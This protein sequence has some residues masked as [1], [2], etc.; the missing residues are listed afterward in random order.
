[1]CDPILVKPGSHMLPTY[2]GYN[3]RHGL[4]QRCGICKHPGIDR[5][6]AY[7]VELSSTSA[8]RPAI[9]GDETI[10]CEHHLRRSVALCGD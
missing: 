10:L 5:R 4:G 3:R 1:M 7:E 6:S 2:L 8:G 9:V